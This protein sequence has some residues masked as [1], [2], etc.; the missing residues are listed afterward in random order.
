MKRSRI[1]N[2]CLV[3][4]MFGIILLLAGCEL[5]G[6]GTSTLQVMFFNSS[7]STYAITSIQLLE[8]GSY[9]DT[10]AAYTPSESWGENIIPVG[11]T[12]PPGKHFFFD[13]NIKAGD[14]CRYRIT[15][16]DTEHSLGAV[17][18]EYALD[19][20][21]YLMT[22]TSWATDKRTVGVSVE[23][24][25]SIWNELY[26]GVYVSSTTDWTGWDEETGTTEVSW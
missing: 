1:R 22:I 4:M 24:S 5:L 16:N 18:L 13:V 17:T 20:T 10:R 21:D 26:D 23:Y 11:Q 3:L 2:M 15:V 6:L 25:E 19:D 12:L 8:G 7:G 14:Y 9:G